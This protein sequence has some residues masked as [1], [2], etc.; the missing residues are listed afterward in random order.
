MLNV[1]SSFCKSCC[2]SGVIFSVLAL[3]TSSFDFI[4]TDPVLAVFLYY[5]IGLIISRIGSLV[6]EPILRKTSF[7]KFA[8]YSDFIMASEKDP[9]IETL[10]ES[11]N[12][13][14]TL[15]SVF[16]S[17]LFLKLYDLLSI[18]SDN[19]FLLIIFILLVFLFSYR[20]Q[21]RY[22]VKRIN[23]SKPHE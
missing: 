9:K 16:V 1:S 3:Q 5:F 11:N 7:V 15:I 23:K 4:Q 17:L 13:Y 2:F 8:R 12:V 19:S 18:T 21:T 14:R 6:V 20:K 22:I 10:S